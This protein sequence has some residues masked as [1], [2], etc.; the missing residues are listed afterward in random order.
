MGRPKI[1]DVKK[2]KAISISVSPEVDKAATDSGNKSKFFEEAGGL[3]I[4]LRA[5]AKDSGNEAA[6][7]EEL[8]NLV[9]E[10]VAI[11]A[12]S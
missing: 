3:I 9:M 1:E 5:A 2:R 7:V 11:R 4:K 12:V 6:F 10:K 8:K